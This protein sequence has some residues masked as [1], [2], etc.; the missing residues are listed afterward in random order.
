MSCDSEWYYSIVTV[1]DEDVSR[2]YDDLLAA[3]RFDYAMSLLEDLEDSYD[4]YH[5]A[6]LSML[7]PTSFDEQFPQVSA[8]MHYHDIASTMYFEHMDMCFHDLDACLPTSDFYQWEDYWVPSA[9]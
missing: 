2:F 3:A 7:Q 9:V 5:P 6:A 1:P 4:L 8:E